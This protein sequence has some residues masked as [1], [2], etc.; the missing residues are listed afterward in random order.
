MPPRTSAV[1]Q[2]ADLRAPMSGFRS[3]ASALPPDSDVGGTSRERLNL[4]PSGSLWHCTPTSA[5]ANSQKTYM[6]E[7]IGRQA[8]GIRSKCS[9]CFRLHKCKARIESS[10]HCSEHSIAYTRF[11]TELVCQQMPTSVMVGKK[12]RCFLGQGRRFTFDLPL[13]R[14]VA[15][16]ALRGNSGEA[17]NPHNNEFRPG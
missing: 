8:R 13:L 1:G 4:T 9:L 17:A 16:P 3:I 2:K 10:A 11:P 5:I 7:Q 12:R 15:R 6:V 14:M